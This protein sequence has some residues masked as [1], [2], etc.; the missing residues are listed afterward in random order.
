VRAKL[1]R[2]LAVIIRSAPDFAAPR[3]VFA[4]SV[5]FPNQPPNPLCLCVSVVQI[6]CAAT[7]FN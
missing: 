7:R 6:P 3:A 2:V 1:G 4:N 5:I